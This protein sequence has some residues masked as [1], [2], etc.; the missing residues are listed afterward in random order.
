MKVH[1]SPIEWYYNRWQHK[2]SLFFGGRAGF[3]G[4]SPSSVEQHS[5]T[6]RFTVCAFHAISAGWVE[7]KFRLKRWEMRSPISIMIERREAISAVGSWR[8]DRTSARAWKARLISVAAASIM[9]E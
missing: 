7:E 9:P 2:R 5:R 6:A 4:K 3:G 1:G 8:I